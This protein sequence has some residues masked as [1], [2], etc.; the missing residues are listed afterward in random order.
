M[1]GLRRGDCVG[2][3]WHIWLLVEMPMRWVKW[4]ERA[5]TVADTDQTR[6]VITKRLYRGKLIFQCL[7]YNRDDPGDAYWLE[8]AKA[9]SIEVHQPQPI[10][11]IRK[12]EL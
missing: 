10:T 7:G 8:G 12:V 6:Y 5:P 2:D 1:V 11:H 4:S 3:D 9:D